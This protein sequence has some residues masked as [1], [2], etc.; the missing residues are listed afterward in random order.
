[1]RD[2]GSELAKK[3][4]S[5]LPV[6]KTPTLRMALWLYLAVFAGTMF[7]ILGLGNS[8]EPLF[9]RFATTI[10]IVLGLMLVAIRVFKLSATSLLGRT[11]EPISLIASIIAGI[12][13]WVPFFWLLDFMYGWLARTVGELPPPLITEAQATPYFIQLGVILTAALFGGYGLFGTDAAT[14]AIPGFFLVGLLA[15]FA[16]YF[17]DSIW[18]GIAVLAGFNLG[19]PLLR[20]RLLFDYFNVQIDAVPYENLFSVRWLMAIAVTGFLSFAL[21]QVIRLRATPEHNDVNIKTRPTKKDL[22]NRLS[23]SGQRWWVPLLLSGILIAFA[24]STEFA[25]RSRNRPAIAPSITITPSPNN[26][27][28]VPIPGQ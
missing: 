27:P 6:S 20:D 26:A 14:S 12:S 21:L 22:G 13:V 17:T 5:F 7:I 8:V 1:M 11:P 19:L 28:A 10:F 2:K 15:T 18:Y 24:V 4:A 16:V 25:L 9:L 23:L 3:P